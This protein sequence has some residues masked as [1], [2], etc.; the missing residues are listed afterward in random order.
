MI[1]TAAMSLLGCAGKRGVLAVALLAVVCAGCSPAPHPHPPPPPPGTEA[2]IADAERLGQILVNHDV[3]ASRATD[4][5]MRM[6][7]PVTSGVATGII[8]WIT[9]PGPTGLVV[10]FVGKSDGELAAF[11]DVRFSLQGVALP[12]RL[13]P[14][15][16]LRESEAAAY[17]ARQIAIEQSTLDCSDRYNTVVFQD[18]MA[19]GDDWL[20]YLLPATTVVGRVMVGRQLRVVVSE[21]GSQ[22]IEQRAL[23]KDC[24]ALDP[25]PQQKPAPVAIFVTN[26]SSPT[27]NESHVYLNLLHGSPFGVATSLGHWM[28]VDGTISYLGAQNDDR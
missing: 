27:P 17:R 13:D 22:V 16:P 19:P 3:A 26:L 23:S 7:V 8:G 9:V 18:P 1:R 6:G 4:A 15:E 10:R 24:L 28:V 5:L 2:E 14:P 11:Y 25:P 12:T 21:D 20:V